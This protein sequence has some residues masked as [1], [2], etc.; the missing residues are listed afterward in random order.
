[1]NFWR[2]R[3]VL[4]TGGAGFIGSHLTTALVTRG[5]RVTVVDNLE[6]GTKGHLGKVL[7][8]IRFFALDLRDPDVALRLCKGMDTVMHLASK[9]G[10]IEYYAYR[11]HDVI[12]ANLSMDGNVL[13]GVLR[14]Y[15][16]HYFYASS[17]HVYP[18]RPQ[19]ISAAQP[20]KENQVLP[21]HPE[22]SYGWGKLVGEKRI[23][24]SRAQGAPLQA[25]V[26]RIIGA[27]GAN[28]DYD[29]QTGSAIP[30]F[31]RR[32]IEYPRLSPF[33]VR[34]TGEESRSYCF[35]DDIVDGIILSVEKL[36][37]TEMVGPFNLGA[38]GSIPINDL[39]RMI[40]DISGKNISITHDSHK[41][42]WIQK[43]EFDCSLAARLLDGWR[44]K[45]SMK[46][47]LKACYLD[48]EARLTRESKDSVAAISVVPTV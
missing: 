30:V 19:T 37:Q 10:G 32:A 25:S 38:E 4:V 12:E 35:V 42:A 48:I 41:R 44:P 29:L 13:N 8:H 20:I 45:V 36:N 3:S 15:V 23:E 31:T 43:Q 47:G 9:V 18:I 34:S 46:D 11:A 16:P 27:Y 28:Q 22:L 14:R 7:D 5:A 2:N 26:A 6:R 33:L 24:F 39:A 40:V 21:A 1:M 17:A